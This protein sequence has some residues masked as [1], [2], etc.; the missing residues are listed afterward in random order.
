MR[1]IDNI[2]ILDFGSQFTQ[3]IA[4]RI[5]ELEVFSEILPWDVPIEKIVSLNPK[6]IILSGG[7]HSA[8]EENA[9]SIDAELL[10]THIPILG[11]CYGMQILAKALGGKVGKGE[12]AEYG[13]SELLNLNCGKLFHGL[14]NEF[15]VWMSHWDQVEVLPA[16]AVATAKS[17]NIL[18]GFELHGGRI[19]GI[20][21]HPEVAHTE[22]GVKV[23]SNFLFKICGCEP[24]WNLNSWLEDEVK[25]ITERISSGH[26]ICGL[27]GGVDSSVAASIAS[28]AG[29]NNLDCIFVD[30]GLLRLH[31]AEQVLK[32]YESMN[33]RV[34]HVD[35]S[36]KFLEALSGV[37]EPERKRKI[38]GETFIRVFEDEAEKICG[39]NCGKNWLL[40]GTLYP[41]VIESGQKGKGASVIKTHH[42]VGGLPD[43]MKFLLLE[44]LKDLFK[45]EVR[46]IGR[47]L[48][49]PERIIKRHPFPGPG[50]AVRCLGE[51]TRERLDVL[52]KADAIFIE[53]IRSADLYDKTWQAFC[54]LLPVKSVGVVGDIRTYGEVIAL[55][56]VDASDGMTA[57]W[58][59]FPHEVLDSTARRICNEIKE[60][61]R[62]VYDV[63]GK[64]PAT[65]EWE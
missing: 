41:D 8:R 32:D 10:K 17:G 5:R 60:V 58:F 37:T 24:S 47:I 40:Q 64:P 3:L 63:T 9:P 39:N 55:R 33:L 29:T 51:I 23:L 21:F 35:A 22:D 57:D 42:N 61:S 36:E 30:H 44:P 26:V 52:R 38:I 1:H 62:V 48:G 65:I 12:Q 54:V 4:R 15:T 53:E 59:R 45:D 11:V 14:R 20:Q 18:A 34:H 43:D 6:G 16:G 13:R 7:P 50:L 19:S 2:L 25:S 56:A 46:Q 28:R 49:V 27:S 31:E